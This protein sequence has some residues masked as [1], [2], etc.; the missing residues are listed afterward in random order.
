MK[1]K[2]ILLDIDGV[3][4]DFCFA[5]TR[6]AMHLDPNQQIVG[7]LD[8]PTWNLTG[9]MDKQLVK[10][11][12]DKIRCMKEWWMRL[13]P[14]ITEPELHRL[15]YLMD[16][17]EV[18]FCTGRK[19]QTRNPDGPS[20]IY[21]TIEWLERLGLTNPSVLMCSKKGEIAR[22]IGATHAIDD[23]PE[24]VCMLEWLNE[25]TCESFVLDRKYN[26]D[27][28]YP[29]GVKHVQTLD[30]F[31]NAILGGTNVESR[32]HEAYERESSQPLT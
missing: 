24:N 22:A 16:R 25:E 23:K 7:T 27:Y 8:Q 18:V 1:H 12:W 5:F 11:T 32:D 17:H 3:L 28:I 31:F 10:A 26:R 9:T 2:R 6:T 19:E 30:E 14:L 20:V 21:Q 29:V 13:P 15:R 4:A